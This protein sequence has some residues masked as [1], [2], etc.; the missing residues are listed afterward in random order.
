MNTRY[1][2]PVPVLYQVPMD[3]NLLSYPD[4]YV[5]VPILSCYQVPGTGTVAAGTLVL[6]H[7]G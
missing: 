4:V 6:Y 5:L 2:V 3:L 7:I 1:Q